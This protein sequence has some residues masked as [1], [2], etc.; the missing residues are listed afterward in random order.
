MGLERLKELAQFEIIIGS[1]QSGEVGLLG[2]DVPN[3][4]GALD[5]EL[6]GDLLSG[7]S[8]GALKI[9][10]RNQIIGYQNTVDLWEL[11]NSAGPEGVGNVAES[12]LAAILNSVGS[13]EFTMFDADPFG[14]LTGSL[15]ED[16]LGGYADEFQGAILDTLGA[17]RFGS[18]G[19]HFGVHFGEVS[20][21]STVFIFLA[22]AAGTEI[23]DG[24]ENFSSL[25][26]DGSSLLQE[27]AL[28]F[29]VGAL[30]GIE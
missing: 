27:G 26:L 4:I 30:F 29:F 2:Q 10:T 19:V 11:V 7:F 22:D 24:R 16:I 12:R 21:G 9:L 23:V 1:F 17:N 13:E 28:E 5:F 20:S 6:H 15:S 8:E 14:A 25:V 18:G 3:V